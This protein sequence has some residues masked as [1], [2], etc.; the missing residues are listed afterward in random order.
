MPG[1]RQ[2]GRDKKQTKTQRIF[3]SA[4]NEVQGEDCTG[5]SVHELAGEAKNVSVCATDSPS[6]IHRRMGRKQ[7]QATDMQGECWWKE[8][9]HTDTR[10]EKASRC[11]NGKKNCP[12]K[13]RKSHGKRNSGCAANIGGCW[14]KG[15]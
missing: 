11:L 15:K 14:K 1:R 8:L 3:A 5:K 2:G 6:G 13:S 10:Q 4:R 7:K 12:K 9:G